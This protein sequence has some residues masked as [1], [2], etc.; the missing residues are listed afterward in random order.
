MAK[1]KL[2]KTAVDAASPKEREYELR[3]T[4]VPGF[5]LKVTPSGGK[6]FMLQYV[7][8]SGV[9]RKPALGRFGELTVDQARKLAQ[10]WLAEVRHGRD[11][12]AEK[13]AARAAPTMKEL[14][15]KFIE[16]HSKLHNKPSTVAGNELNIKN[17]ILPRIGRFKAHE[18]TRAHISELM[19]GLADRPVIANRTLACLRKMFNLAELW[20][21]RP[22]G[23]NPCRHVQKFAEKGTTRFITDDEMRKLF[24][25]LDKADREGLEHPFIILAI[26]LQFEFAARMSE[27]LMLEWDWIDLEQRR[28]TWPDSKTGGM[29]KPLSDEAHRLLSNAP[30]FEDSPFVCPSIFDPSKRMTDNT[31][32]H[33]WRRILKRAEVPHVGTHGIRHRAATDIANSGV[34]LKVGMA[35]TA[36]K[37]VTM[38]MRYIHN[39]DDPV[40]IAADAVAARRRIVVGGQVGNVEAPPAEI[41]IVALDHEGSPSAETS[42]PD[43]PPAGF[44]DGKYS[45]RTKTGNYRPFR[46]RS[47]SNR[48]VPP[49]TRH[50]ENE[51]AAR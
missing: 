13:S 4:T 49:G 8:N 2:T 17:H 9:R 27:V 1:I 25:Y 36:H 31:Y 5:M 22:D 26:R 18:V 34:P 40:R 50:A 47:G 51:E 15:T 16:E 41:D 23:S 43:T 20:G 14:C 30:R 45:S 10:D 3:D 24:S 46:H 28:V 21:Y 6:I 44:E 33:G 37:T 39:E 38:F 35:L 19:T 48:A 11:P 12:S 7:N 42:A 32:H 29:T